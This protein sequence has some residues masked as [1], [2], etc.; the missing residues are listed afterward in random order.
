MQSSNYTDNKYSLIY[1]YIRVYVCTV[2]RSVDVSDLAVHTTV[3][4][5][6]ANHKVRSPQQNKGAVRGPVTAD[7]TSH[8]QREQL[9]HSIHSRSSKTLE[10]HHSVGYSSSVW[11]IC[12]NTR[13]CEL[14]PPLSV[15]AFFQW[16]VFGES[17]VTV[18]RWSGSQGG[19]QFGEK[20]AGLF[21]QSLSMFTRR[22]V[23]LG[24][25]SDLEK[26]VKLFGN[27]VTRSLISYVKSWFY[28]QY[29]LLWIH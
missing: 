10:H 15:L 18:Q 12:I 1:S 29:W 17:E 11:L 3:V 28:I 23:Q 6:P 27:F 2:H 22:H 16:S 7:A 21:G 14:I 25:W 9:L 24:V 8:K 4:D 20:D 5:L 26:E 19:V 13:I